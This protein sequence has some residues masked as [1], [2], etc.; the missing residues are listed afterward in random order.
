MDRSEN[1]VAAVT[2]CAGAVVLDDLGRLLAVRRR[3]EPSRGCWS[4]P[5]GRVEAGEATSDAARREVLEET[6]LRV[7]IGAHLGVLRQAYVDATGLHRVLEI[8]D[9]AACVRGGTLVPG[10]DALDARWLARAQLRNLPL[11]PGLL[12]ALAG[13]AVQIR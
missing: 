11:T 7:E 2:L 9:Y 10:D 1:S 6:G 4:V 13:F 12:E 5:G 8:H 3:N